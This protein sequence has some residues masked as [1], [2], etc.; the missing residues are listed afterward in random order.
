MKKWIWVLLVAISATAAKAQ[1]KVPELKWT[2]NEDGS[3]YVKFTAL[4]Q[5]WL[6]YNQNNPGSEV[7]GGGLVPHPKEEKETFDIGLRR[8][9]FQLMGSLSEKTFFYV[10][11][12][13]NNLNYL[14]TR[15]TGFFLH[16][17]LGEYN[18]SKH[19]GIGAGI[20]GWTGFSRYSAPSVGNIVGF[21]APLYLQATNDVN[22]QFLRKLSVYA[23]GKLGKL[24]YR[25]IVSKPFELTTAANPGSAYA[26][27]GD[28]KFSPYSP[29]LQQ[30]G[31][32][33]YAFKDEES[34]TT[35]YMTGTYLGTKKVFNV[36]AGFE[37]QQDAMWL[38]YDAG[39]TTFHHML[40]TAV[41]VVYDAPINKEKGS[42]L[43]F[44]CVFTS[45]DFGKN[46]LRNIGPMNPMDAVNANGTLN[47]EGNKAPLVGTGNTV[48]VQAA[49]LLPHSLESVSKAR[50]MPYASCQV[51]QYEK[52]KDNMI[53]YEAGC[54]ILTD[55]HRSKLTVGAQMRPIFDAA[56]L[57]QTSY[58]TMA[59]VQYQLAFL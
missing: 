34:N 38:K 10:Q 8:V 16:D 50:F 7:S 33:Y 5:T 29:H 19:L 18:F 6:R 25:L 41:D 27:S 49:F 2:F 54:A 20:T 22:D 3:K 36:G 31:Y 43:H 23:K 58:K 59:V 1:T 56:S 13:Q 39:D 42:A 11:L 30:S 51:S 12:G 9:R 55:G 40:L 35:P 24:D 52:L 26:P 14:T 28:A 45:Y 48:F 32:L 46:Y 15:K 37:Y 21:D 17:A 44:Y 57:Q 47:A 4:A 53:M